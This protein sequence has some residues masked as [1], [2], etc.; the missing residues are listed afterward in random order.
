MI[1]GILV[2]LWSFLKFVYFVSLNLFGICFVLTC[3]SAH[4]K[5]AQEVDIISL[6]VEDWGEYIMSFIQ[7]ALLTACPIVNTIMAIYII[8]NWKSFRDDVATKAIVSYKKRL[9]KYNL[10]N[11]DD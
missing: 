6:P 9:R 8:T 2:G 7:I 5:V 10:E 4:N 11:K 1:T 3:Y